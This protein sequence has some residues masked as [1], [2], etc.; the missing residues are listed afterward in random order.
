MEALKTNLLNINSLKP[1]FERIKL[2]EDLKK[3][4]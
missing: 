1:L 4:I 3:A 2:D